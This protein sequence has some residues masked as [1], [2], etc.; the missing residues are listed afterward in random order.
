MQTMAS[1]AKKLSHSMN[2]MK[3]MVERLA[4]PIPARAND[5]AVPHEDNEVVQPLD[6][7]MRRLLEE[8]EA[9]DDCPEEECSRWKGPAVIIIVGILCLV[10]IISLL[11]SAFAAVPGSEPG[12]D[13]LASE[14][15][16]TMRAFTM[17]FLFCLSLK[18]RREFISLAGS[19]SLLEPW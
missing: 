9:E 4:A 10:P 3:I 1:I 8:T 14:E 7:N 6:D 2:P 13:G 17:G 18:L 16:G 15:S 5:I 12:G 19:S 11:V